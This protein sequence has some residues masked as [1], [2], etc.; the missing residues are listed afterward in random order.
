MILHTWHHIH[1]RQGINHIHKRKRVLTI[2]HSGHHILNRL[3][4]FYKSILIN[5][6]NAKTTFD[7]STR[8]QRF[9][10]NILSLSCWYSL[11]EYPQTLW[12]GFSHFSAFL[13]HFVLAKLATSNI[14]VKHYRYRALITFHIGHHIDCRNRALKIFYTEHHIHINTGRS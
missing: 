3:M 14:R 6:S 2:S 5:P 9:L 12:Q 10:K 8:M 13:H 7:Q 1:N 4:I 11:G